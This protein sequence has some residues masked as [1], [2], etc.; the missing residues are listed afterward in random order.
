MLCGR[1]LTDP[2]S[3]VT[4]VGPECVKQVPFIKAAAR[5]KVLDV[6]RLRFDGGRLIERFEQA[7]ITELAAFVAEA[8]A[9]ETAASQQSS[10]LG[11]TKR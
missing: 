1:H 4:G 7:G 5:A 2:A 10:P 6:G 3:I 8:Q 9:E 11:G